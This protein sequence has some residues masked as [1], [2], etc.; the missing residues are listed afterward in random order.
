MKKHTVFTLFLIL[1]GLL[2]CTKKNHQIDFSKKID[3]EAL[4]ENVQNNKTVLPIELVS[5]IVQQSIDKITVYIENYTDNYSNHTISYHWPTTR[6]KSIETLDGQTITINSHDA[7]GLSFFSKTNKHDFE[8]K[9]T[10]KDFIQSQIDSI[11]SNTNIHP[12]IAIAE[13]TYLSE[14]VKERSYQLEQNDLIMA[15]WEL[16]NEALHVFYDGIAFTVTTNFNDSEIAKNNAVLMA[17]KVLTHY[18]IDN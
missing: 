4:L 3:S 17:K 5:E 10:S 13:A 14:S 16:P 18:T 2:A 9:Y 12:D 6:S 15:F 11:V 1:L 8:K 7:I